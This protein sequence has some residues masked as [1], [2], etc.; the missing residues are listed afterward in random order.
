M[1][2]S[3]SLFAV[4]VLLSPSSAIAAEWVNVTA[5]AVGDRFFVDKSAIQR[6]DANVWFWEYREFP[7]PNNAFLEEPV[8]QAVHGVVL[9]WSAN[10]TSKTQRLRQVTAYTQDRKVI[11]KFGY[12]ETGNLSQPRAGSSASAVLG[13]VCEGQ[14]QK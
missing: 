7:K 2:F 12:G 14:G 8:D 10:C 4:A 6:K 9:N 1:R 5:N 13:Y 11:R 3:L